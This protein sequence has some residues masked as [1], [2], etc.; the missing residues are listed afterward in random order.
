M[1]VVGD[2]AASPDQPRHVSG[3][4]APS[5]AL[6][7]VLILSATTIIITQVDSRPP[8]DYQLH[9]LLIGSDL[10]L[11]VLTLI[12]S[13]GL[14]AAIRSWRRHA[15]A[16]GALAV[17]IAMVPALV[18]H[19]SD[20]GAAALLRWAGAVAVGI[21]VGS[22]RREGRRLVIG[23]LAAV[24]LAHVAVAWAERAADGTVGLGALGEPHAYSIGGRYASSGLT[25]HPYLLAAWCAVA[26][27]ALL[28]LAQRRQSG[29]GL[30]R[31]AGIA[32]FGGIGLTMSRAGAVAGTLALAA[33]AVSARRAPNHRAGTGA[34]WRT[35]AAAA[36]LAV[37]ILVNLSG[38]ASRAGQASGSIDAVSSGRGALLRQAWALLQDH[39][40][41]GV[42]PGRYVLALS[43][44]PAIVAL[45]AQSPR[46]VHVTPLLLLVE[47]GVL[48]IPALILLG[49]AV[50]RA[51]LR[52]G[53]PAVAVTL[54]MLPFLA[55]DHLA[56]SYPQGI[57]LTGVWLGVLDLLGRRTGECEDEAPED[58]AH[59]ESREAPEP[60]RQ[61]RDSPSSLS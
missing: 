17:G 23:A 58:A 15:C 41:T 6:A 26:G 44:R 31:V 21:G 46:P 52:G 9:T 56:W 61:P 2:R 45:S 12:A 40:V 28:A 18:I 55:L 27:T 16:L 48:V 33:L 25:V 47:G 22:A 50:R 7:V 35:I 30:A 29:G 42:G 1:T 39:P 59:A 49:L 5:L 24:S 57:V 8:G 54:A 60:R 11:L 43:E 14:P 36:A 53:A 34:S 32:A 10:A 38:W 13:R 51:C 3:P 20:R 19:P 37:G 4:D